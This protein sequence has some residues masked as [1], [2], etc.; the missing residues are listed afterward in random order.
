[1]VSIAEC[2]EDPSTPWPRCNHVLRADGI[3]AIKI[4]ENGALTSLSLNSLRRIGGPGDHSPTSP[5]YIKDNE[6]LCLVDKIDW[7]ELSAATL[8]VGTSDGECGTANS[9][10]I[11]C[12]L[13]FTVEF[14]SST[15]AKLSIEG[16]P[17]EVQDKFR[18]QP[19]HPVTCQA[20]EKQCSALCGARGCWDFSTAGCQLCPDAADVVRSGE[21]VSGGCEAGDPSPGY[22]ELVDTP[23]IC[24]ECHSS[25]DDCAG[26]SEKDCTVLCFTYNLHAYMGLKDAVESPIGVLA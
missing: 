19:V 22:F 16:F 14:M 11:P 24:E 13:G 17:Q 20:Q 18:T 1:V 6:G 2:D 8:P 3:Y 9:F 15:R 26:P 21:C 10:S 23:G 12:N 4:S 25:C 7:N 5:I